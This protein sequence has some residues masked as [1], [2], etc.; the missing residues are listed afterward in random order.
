MK[1]ENK[2]L[3]NQGT[4]QRWFLFIMSSSGFNLRMI[5]KGPLAFHYCLK[6]DSDFVAA[7]DDIMMDNNA[8]SE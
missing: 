3:N 8:K 6:E 5:N 7:G 2:S 4:R 1:T